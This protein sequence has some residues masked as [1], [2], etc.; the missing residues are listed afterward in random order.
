MSS[1]F[2]QTHLK[3]A[4]E[5]LKRSTKVTMETVGV[6]FCSRLSTSVYREHLRRVPGTSC[7][8]LFSFAVHIGVHTLNVQRFHFELG[9]C[10]VGS[11]ILQPP[12][13]DRVSAFFSVDGGKPTCLKFF[14][15]GKVR[16]LKSDFPSAD[17][18]RKTAQKMIDDTVVIANS[19]MPPLHLCDARCNENSKDFTWSTRQ[20]IDV[21]CLGTA[22]RKL[23]IKAE[24][25][26]SFGDSIMVVITPAGTDR[27]IKGQVLADGTIRLAGCRDDGELA[28]RE[29][30]TSLNNS[31][32]LQRGSVDLATVACEVWLTKRSFKVC[33]ERQSINIDKLYAILSTWP[34]K[35]EHPVLAM[36]VHEKGE[37]QFIKSVS[38]VG[39]ACPRLEI[40]FE[41]I[42]INEWE[43]SRRCKPEPISIS[44]HTQGEVQLAGNAEYKVLQAVYYF[45]DIFNRHGDILLCAEGHG[46][47]GNVSHSR[48]PK[49]KLEVK[50]SGGGWEYDTHIMQTPADDKKTGSMTETPCTVVRGSKK[51]M[52][53]FPTSSN[54][55]LDAG[56]PLVMGAAVIDSTRSADLFHDR[57]LVLLALLRK[58]QD[59]VQQSITSVPVQSS[60]ESTKLSVFQEETL[61]ADSADFRACGLECEGEWRMPIEVPGPLL[62]A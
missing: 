34:N 62:Q 28:A 5:E 15:T 23:G 60:L 50:T 7:L 14:S 43:R 48:T 12:S 17:E 16:C 18:A 2:D 30:A 54:R 31:G 42:V 47:F 51:S 57:Q 4:I 53:A 40:K 44:I 32:A 1:L 49:R 20:S 46:A 8:P 26:T 58:F 41:P 35:C 52:V 3:L 19:G 9:S 10:S 13:E 61:D 25:D 27:Q 38:K 45:K 37:K 39:T 24:Y 59:D 56:L 21:R 29:V 33:P 36:W 55:P 22:L 6:R 11:V